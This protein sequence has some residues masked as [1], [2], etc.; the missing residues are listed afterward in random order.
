[1]KKMTS[2]DKSGSTH[3]IFSTVPDRCIKF[4]VRDSTCQICS[5]IQYTDSSLFKLDGSG[6]ANPLFEPTLCFFR[7]GKQTHHHPV[8]FRINSAAGPSQLAAQ[9]LVFKRNPQAVIQCDQFIVSVVAALDNHIIALRTHPYLIEISVG[10]SFHKH[11]RMTLC[12]VISPT[13]KVGKAWM[14]T[15]TCRADWCA[16]RIHKRHFRLKRSI[17]IVKNLH[18]GQCGEVLLSVAFFI[19]SLLCAG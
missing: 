7:E 13:I 17:Q 6:T 16:S 14:D 12:I 1:M 3:S 8:L 5:G 2:C 10:I 11:H 9:G 4:Q 18:G 19:Q 15:H